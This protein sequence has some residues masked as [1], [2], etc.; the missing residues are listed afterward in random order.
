[1]TNTAKP[2]TTHADISRKFSAQMEGQLDELKRQYEGQLEALIQEAVRQKAGLERRNRFR[3]YSATD[4]L[5]L[6][7]RVN[8]LFTVAV[9]MQRQ[10]TAIETFKDLLAWLPPGEL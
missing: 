5:N 4:A 7:S 1:M 10:Q 2:V 8:N 9:E 3:A 6:Q